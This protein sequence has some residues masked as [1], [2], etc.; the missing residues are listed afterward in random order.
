MM[1]QIIA[2]IY[3]VVM[4]VAT[5]AQDYLNVGVVNVAANSFANKTEQAIT[6][7]KNLLAAHPDVD[8][9]LTPEYSFSD[10]F[11]DDHIQLIKSGDIYLLDKANS[12]SKVYDALGQMLNIAREKKVNML[13]ATVALELKIDQKEYP[14]LNSQHV[15][16]AVLIVNN[17]G[18]IVDYDLKADYAGSDW[19][20]IN[21]FTNSETSP[22][23]KDAIRFTNS[24][25]KVRT[26]TSRSGT[27]YRYATIICAERFG[28]QMLDK[29]KDARVDLVFY[30][31][32][33][34][35][36]GFNT[37]MDNIQN[38]GGVEQ[39]KEDTPLAFKN[40]EQS[41]YNELM[42][43]NAIDQNS[44][45]VAAELYRPSVCILKY[46]FNK[47]ERLDYKEDEYVYAPVPAGDG[48]NDDSDEP[49]GIEN[50]KFQ[51]TLVLYPNPTNDMVYIKTKNKGEQLK[52]RIYSMQGQLL[53][54]VHTNSGQ[55][56]S[57]MEFDKGIFIVE[58]QD[59]INRSVFKRIRR[60]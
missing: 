43:R 1:K 26:L 5:Q 39:F 54:T 4:V 58:I 32:A 41:Y 21:H 15:C 47:V 20:D 42:R 7:T 23:G 25:T 55:P 33:E 36:F 38:G 50:E 17:K 16:N 2:V 8:V 51:T 52:V 3:L 37:L 12:S 30:C 27:K 24:T 22:T 34:G 9:I 40:F 48:N 35:D 19:I 44:Y 6:N 45:L 49:T 56:V 60:N 13:L 29:Y 14:H 59:V 46:D 10:G 28:E 11:Y 57:L 53:K 31:E 18:Q